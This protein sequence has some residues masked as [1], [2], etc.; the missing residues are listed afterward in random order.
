MVRLFS[1]RPCPHL[2]HAFREIDLQKIL[3]GFAHPVNSF[4]WSGSY[5]AAA[6]GPGN[7]I[8][9]RIGSPRFNEPGIFWTGPGESFTRLGAPR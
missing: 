2:H 3:A 5:A 4:A 8:A 7:P 9:R 6:L 1:S